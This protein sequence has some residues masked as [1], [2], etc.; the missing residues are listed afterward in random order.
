VTFPIF[1]G[2]LVTSGAHEVT[3][4]TLVVYTVEV[5]YFVTSVGDEGGAG[6]PVGPAGE[7]PF[8]CDSVTGQ[9]VV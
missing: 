2:Q 4:Y 1:A 7:P 8:P 9:T 6:F 3:V 5:V